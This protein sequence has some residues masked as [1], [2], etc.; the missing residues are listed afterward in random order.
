MFK[1]IE[2]VLF[3]TWWLWLPFYVPFLS[4]L[5]LCWD[6]ERT[7]VTNAQC[8]HSPRFSSKNN[9]ISSEITSEL[10]FIYN[11]TKQFLLYAFTCMLSW[12][13]SEYCRTDSN[14]SFLAHVFLFRAQK[15]DLEYFSL[16]A[17][18]IYFHWNSRIW[19][20]L[21]TWRFSCT[22]LLQVIHENVEWSQSKALNTL[23]KTSSNTKTFWRMVEKDRFPFTD[24]ILILF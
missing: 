14:V 17:S 19:Y 5:C 3:H 7:H 6:V 4:L 8:F 18:I 1:N 11:Y 9:V 24:V 22:L 15:W 10:F 16:D 2:L 21:K 20:H 12:Q 23:F 13:L